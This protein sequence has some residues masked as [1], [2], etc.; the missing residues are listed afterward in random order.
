MST[1]AMMSLKSSSATCSASRSRGVVRDDHDDGT[2]GNLK[3]IQQQSLVWE[4]LPVISFLPTMHRI[5]LGLSCHLD[6]LLNRHLQRERVYIW[7]AVY[8]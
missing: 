4:F 6:A 7:N 5:A 8:S 3:L 1:F 2:L